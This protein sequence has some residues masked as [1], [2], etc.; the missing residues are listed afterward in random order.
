[1]GW[2]GH[3]EAGGEWVPPLSDLDLSQSCPLLWPSTLA[4]PSY[5]GVPGTSHVKGG[6]PLPVNGS[7][8]PSSRVRSSCLAPDS[9]SSQTCL[10]TPSHLAAYP[11]SG[12]WLARRVNELSN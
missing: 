7:G 4:H 10:P 8:I 1:M 11:P 2:M 12:W 5:P 9:V 6:V 3:R